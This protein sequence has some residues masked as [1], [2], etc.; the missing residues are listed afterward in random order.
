[1]TTTFTALTE[2]TDIDAGDWFA[3]DDTSANTTKK[4]DWKTVKKEVFVIACSDESTVITATGEKVEFRIPYAFTVTAVRGSLTTACTT[5][6]FTVDINESGTTILSTKLT[7]D[8]TEKTTTTASTAAVI[9]DAV[10]A[11]D[12]EIQIDVDNV[13][14]SLATGLKIYIIGYQT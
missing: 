2:L 4:V 11:D 7:F 9:S 6:T 5:G 14:D 10:L 1:M 3:I 8:A 12:A 13:G